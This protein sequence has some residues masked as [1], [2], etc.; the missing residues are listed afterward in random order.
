MSQWKR[1]FGTRLTLARFLQVFMLHPRLLSLG[2]RLIAAIPALGQ[3][4]VTH[5]RGSYKE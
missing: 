4:L 5:T 2:L 3:S 1:E